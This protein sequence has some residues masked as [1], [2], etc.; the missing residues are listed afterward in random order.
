MFFKLISEAFDIEV[1]EDAMFFIHIY[2]LVDKTSIS[3]LHQIV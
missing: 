2:S 3:E 1:K